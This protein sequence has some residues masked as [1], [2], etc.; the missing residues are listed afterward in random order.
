MAI[1]KIG[2]ASVFETSNRV[3]LQTLSSDTLVDLN[4]RFTSHISVSN[5]GAHV[6]G[7][8]VGLQDALDDKAAVSHSH[9]IGDVTG[10]QGALDGKQDVL[11][12]FTGS[13]T[14]VT[15]V[16]FVGESVTTK[17]M[18]YSNGVLT[19]VV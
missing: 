12:G 8:V 7:S 14:V 18:T 6:I 1:G 13:V 10:L 16:D 11:I 15:G 19:S 9:A 3:N 17:T 5:P 4:N 2:K